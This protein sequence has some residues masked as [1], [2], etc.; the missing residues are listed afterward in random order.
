MRSHLDSNVAN[1]TPT[2]VPHHYPA[3]KR[4]ATIDAPLT[5]LNDTC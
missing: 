5:R 4:R 1:A 2:L 3:L